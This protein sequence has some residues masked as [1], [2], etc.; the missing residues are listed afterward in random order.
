MLSLTLREAG[1]QVLEAANG[2]EALR[3]LKEQ[4]IKVG[5][6]VTDVVMPQMGGPQL[7]A[8]L[9]EQTPGIKVIYISGHADD[10]V[11]RAGTLDSA[12]TY[13]QKP[14]TPAVLTHKIQEVLG[15]GGG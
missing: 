8:V 14:F 11:L 13:L 3:L 7:V 9:K 2:R 5:M 10:A 4:P 12:T 15:A 6:I 1:Y